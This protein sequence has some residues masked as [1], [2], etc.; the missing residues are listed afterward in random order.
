TRRL[1]AGSGRASV[2]DPDRARQLRYVEEDCRVGA[3][4]RVVVGRFALAV[5]FQSSHGIAAQG[6]ATIVGP[7]TGAA[8]DAI[9]PRLRD[10]SSARVGGFHLAAVAAPWGLINVATTSRVVVAISV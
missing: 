9:P 2:A 8:P 4:R 1:R 10:R 7:M 5:V 3:R 6:R